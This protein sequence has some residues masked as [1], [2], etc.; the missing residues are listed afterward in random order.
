MC[1]N[2]LIDAINENKIWN[3]L[4]KM[5]DFSKSETIELTTF[6]NFDKNWLG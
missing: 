5:Y 1:A 6:E 4:D 3:F 2:D